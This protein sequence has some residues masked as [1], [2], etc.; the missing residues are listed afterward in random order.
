MNTYVNLLAKKKIIN[1][2]SLSLL[3]MVE[4]EKME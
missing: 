3:Q 1:E 2:A 4:L